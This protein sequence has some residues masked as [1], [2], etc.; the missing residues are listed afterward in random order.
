M[1]RSRVRSASSHSVRVDIE[2]SPVNSMVFVYEDA[3]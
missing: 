3:T 2:M 1:A